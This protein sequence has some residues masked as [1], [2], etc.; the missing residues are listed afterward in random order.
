[1]RVRVLPRFCCG[2]GAGV[3]ARE[4]GRVKGACVRSVRCVRC[5]LLK[6]WDFPRYGRP[7][8]HCG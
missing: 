4:R 1:M 6:L 8:G 5:A 7:I 2:W 3:S